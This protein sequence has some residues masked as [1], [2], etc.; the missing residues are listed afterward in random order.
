MSSDGSDTSTGRRRILD[1]WRLVSPTGARVVSLRQLPKR[2]RARLLAPST[3][4]TLNM[5]SG[6][7]SVL[8][9]FRGH[10]TLAAVLIAFS[11]VMD[12]ADGFVARLVGA[13]SPFGLQLD[14]LADL[15]SFGVAPAVLVHTWA[16]RD[17]PVL[18]WLVAFLWLS[19]A[20]FRLARFNVTIDPAADKRYFVGLPSPG[21][22]SV[23]IA[24]IFALDSP[25]FGPG[26][27][28]W[29]AWFPL[30]VS[31]V[32]AFLMVMTIRFR[33]FRNLLQPTTPG[34]RLTT[35]LVAAAIVI[36]LVVAPGL[37]GIVV[38]YGY[39]LTA[40]LGVLTAPL[41]E[42]LLGSESVAP[43]RRRMQS[44]FLPIE[45]DDELDGPDP[46]DACDEPGAAS[47]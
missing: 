34:A 4:T 16:L 10:F 32:P 36:G 27:G 25:F 2:E 12:I 31:V 15:I 22:A 30:L 23:V 9:A 1:R 8:L 33:S 42:R 41:R 21:A 6:F 3:F 47:A 28:P 17:W 24:T 14:S 35:G 26:T 43:P 20:A 44:V 45:G 13:T 40:P 38:A 29:Q 7:S 19:C 39:V 37:T 18:A 46:D 11:I 5:V